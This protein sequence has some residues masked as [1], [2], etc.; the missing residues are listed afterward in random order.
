MFDV[1]CPGHG[2]RVLLFTGDIKEVRNTEAG[3]EVHY[4]CFCGHEGVWLT[5]REPGEDVRRV[6]PAACGGRVGA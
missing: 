1:Y 3:I 6:S 5:G 2:S 4:H